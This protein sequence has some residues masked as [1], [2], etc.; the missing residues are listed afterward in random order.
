[1]TLKNQKMKSN[2]IIPAIH[3][4][5]IVSVLSQCLDLITLISENPIRKEAHLFVEHLVMSLRE[6]SFYVNKYFGENLDKKMLIHME[7][8]KYI[9]DA[10]C[11]RSSPQNLLTP[12]FHISGG[13]N[14][15][16][17]DIEVQ[18]GKTKIMLMEGM[19]NLYLYFRKIITDSNEFAYMKRNPYWNIEQ[20]R[21]EKV[22]KK[23]VKALSTDAIVKKE[24]DIH[25]INDTTHTIASNPI[26]STRNSS[27]LL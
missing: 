14:I 22:N 16:N 15:K 25:R 19:V 9:R 20:R 8:V 3:E 4:G 2:R 7:G 12:N 10:I 26:K 6:L 18:Y 5:T 17:N 27:K 1:M 21:L 23:L 13:F 24:F 11:H